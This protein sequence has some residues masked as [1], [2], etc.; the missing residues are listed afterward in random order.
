MGI[1]ET[2]RA[3]AEHR[4]RAAPEASGTLALVDAL[5]QD[6]RELPVD[7][8]YA[9]TRR[10]RRIA[11]IVRWYFVKDFGFRL[12]GTFWCAPTCSPGLTPG[13]HR[14]QAKAGVAVGERLF[15]VCMTTCPTCTDGGW[16]ICRCFRW[17]K[18][19]IGL[20]HPGRMI[21]LWEICFGCMAARPHDGWRYED[22]RDGPVA[23]LLTPAD[24]PRRRPS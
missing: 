22:D 7:E 24:L 18:G 16:L 6:W 2:L 9:R 15:D 11:G 5:Q 20:K 23:D 13:G 10:A 14:G 21:S 8:E 1:R 12:D 3:I 19:C 17:S 4:K